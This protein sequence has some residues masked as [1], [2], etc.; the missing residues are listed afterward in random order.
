[1]PTISKLMIKSS[2]AGT[3][4]GIEVSRFKVQA[5]VFCV[6]SLGSVIGNP[7]VK[8]CEA[9]KV[10]IKFKWKNNCIVH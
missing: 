9:T 2:A 3:A 10:D 7:N 1:M 6:T 5:Y 4:K 8:S